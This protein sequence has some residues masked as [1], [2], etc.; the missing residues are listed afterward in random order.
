VRRAGG[1]NLLLLALLLLGLGSAALGVADRVRGVEPT[2]AVQMA[3]L[4]LSTG[5]MVSLTGLRRWA[6]GLV[7]A[8]AGVGAVFSRVGR[9]GGAV[10]GLS[11]AWMRL[12]RGVP[13]WLR[14]DGA[15]AWRPVWGIVVDVG[16]D[17]ATLLRRIYDWAVA[18]A[19]GAPTFDPVAVAFVWS[20]GL[21]SVGGWAGWL[22]YRREQ[23]LWALAPAGVLLMGAF[24]HVWGSHVFLLVLLL[25]GFLLLALIAYDRRMRRW[26]AS[27][28]DYPEVRLETAVVTVF[29]SLALVTTAYVV[30]SVSLDRI[31]ELAREIGGGRSEEARAVAESLGMER[32]ERTVLEEVRRGGLPRRHLL[33]TGPELAERVVMIIS[34]GDLSPGPPGA[35]DVEPPRYAW[36]SHSYDRYTG[37]G[38]RAGETETIAYEAGVPAVTGTLGTS[39]AQR[40]VRQEVRVVQDAGDLLHAAGT[41]LVAD[42]DYRV[43]WRSPEDPFGATIRATSYRADSIVSI[44]PEEPLRADGS[45]YP[46]WVRERYL[47]L[48]ESVPGRV[49]A[50]ARDL[51]ATEPTP[52]GRARAIETYLRRFPYT[53]DVPV[54]PRERDVVDYFLFDLQKGYCDYYAS[55]MTVLARAAGLPARLAVGYASGT[56]DWDSARYLVTEADAHAWPEVY[57]PSHGWVRFEPT[58]GL[59]PIEHSDEAASSAWAEPEG[60]LEPAGRG[61]GV[62]RRTWLQGLIGGL[63]VLGL[64]VAV[65]RALDR[66]R[67]RR[68]Q[69][70]EAL[71]S[72]YRRLRRYGRRLKV[73]MQAGDTPHE[74][75]AALAGWMESLVPSRSVDQP[76]SE[77][78]P[79]KVP[80]RA[81]PAR[82]GVAMAAGAE[83]LTWLTG[84]YARASYSPRSPDAAEQ[85]QAVRVWGRLR[86][87]LLLA[88]FWR[89]WRV[90]SE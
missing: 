80:R 74:F 59:A 83:E 26:E 30:P 16:T 18:L 9:L 61:W 44:A 67:L 81:R 63:A 13:Q 46:A 64:T 5:W 6:A 4:G 20:L 52:Y 36:R 49:L 23:P 88:Q 22:T 56:Y 82:V 34:T 38:W 10:V 24:S 51:T 89:R 53:L 27:G 25:A 7:T 42:H 35:T 68:Q 41:L 90:R 66:R 54:P 86:W 60:A 37:S 17:S 40:V 11:P 70:V 71:A 69:P 72:L 77:V 43:A 65:C 1:R 14:S 39:T 73:P 21:W 12:M 28:V 29:M 55:A 19:A 31:V 50:L 62:L 57:F 15:L 79:G 87:R 85:A 33:G 58:A 32:R 45:D 48:P 2:L 78:Q 3:L 47:G 84:L 8:I 76:R 75:G